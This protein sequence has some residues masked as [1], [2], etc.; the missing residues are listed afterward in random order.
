[1]VGGF[2]GMGLKTGSCGLVIWASKSQ[3]WFLSLGYKTKR[4]MVCQFHH[5]TDGR[6]MA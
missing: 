1:M 3:Q 6:R 4:A 5:K 2:P